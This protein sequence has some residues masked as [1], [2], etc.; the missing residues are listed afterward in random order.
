[1]KPTEAFELWWLTLLSDSHKVMNLFEESTYY[2]AS[3]EACM[4]VFHAAYN[5]GREAGIEEA[6]M[7]FNG[8]WLPTESRQKLNALKEKS[9]G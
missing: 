1:M 8:V 5:M 6:G 9:N 3:Q 4:R 7:V 2:G